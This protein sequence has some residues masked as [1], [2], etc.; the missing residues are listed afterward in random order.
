MAS[1]VVIPMNEIPF[2]DGIQILDA[3]RTGCVD[4]FV[5][6]EREGHTVYTL[7]NSDLPYSALVQRMQQGA[8]M[9]NASGY[10]IFANPSL[11]ALLGNSCEAIV[12]LRFDELM[13]AEDRAAFGKL[14]DELQM[15]SSEG[16]L[17]L[18]R[19]DET[20]IPIR[21]S[22]TTLSRDKSVTGVLVGDL[23]TEKS[24]AELASRIQSVEDDERKKIA[25]EMHDSVGQLLAVLAMNLTT[26][27]ANNPN[28]ASDSAALLSDCGAMV[29]QVNREIRTISHLLHPPLLDVAGLESAIRWYVDGFS[30]RSNIKV[31]LQI[32]SEL[33]RLS[34]E[35]EICIFRVVQ[36]CLTNVYR[37]SGSDF[38]AISMKRDGQY[39]YME[40]RDTGHGMRNAGKGESRPG[41]GLRGMQER[42]R[43][44]GGTLQIDS[45]ENGTVVNVVVPVPAKS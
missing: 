24:L 33:G 1:K 39:L 17:R 13:V 35:V 45:S 19:A 28:L 15:G 9:L 30:Y 21:V 27:S 43:R 40:I 3:I 29:D 4:A 32:D 11:A 16:E 23:S 31:D 8:A 5:V 2:E 34:S 14:L 41:V 25:R 44:I 42:L 12:G 22:L 18:R 38:S 26:L 37:H 36:E 6:E 20:I 7:G 10:V